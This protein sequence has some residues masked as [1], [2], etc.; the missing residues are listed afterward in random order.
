MELE[1]IAKMN[2]SERRVHRATNVVRMQDPFRSSKRS[3]L[4][5]DADAR[6]S[7]FSRV[8]AISSRVAFRANVKTALGLGQQLL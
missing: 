7:H 2:R 8:S 4:R 3:D 6:K 1:L 5:H